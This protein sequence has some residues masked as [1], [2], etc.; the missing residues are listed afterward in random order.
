MKLSLELDNDCTCRFTSAVLVAAYYYEKFK[1]DIARIM[2]CK[3]TNPKVEAEFGW[4]GK[5]VRKLSTSTSV[6]LKFNVKGIAE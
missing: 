3:F 2:Q 1:M 5:H 4:C 6:N